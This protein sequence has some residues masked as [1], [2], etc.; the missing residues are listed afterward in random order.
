[1][2]TFH[3]PSSDAMASP[4]SSRWSPRSAGW[5]SVPCRRSRHS[6]ESETRSTSTTAPDPHDTTARTLRRGAGRL[7]SEDD[8]VR[9]G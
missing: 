8:T 6:A 5:S 3:P 2:N 9:R 4:S 1:M 7:T